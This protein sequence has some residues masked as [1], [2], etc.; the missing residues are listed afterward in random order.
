[1]ASEANR[2]GRIVVPNEIGHGDRTSWN[3]ELCH[4]KPAES[5]QPS[6]LPARPIPSA[7]RTGDT[8][9]LLSRV[10]T[11]FVHSIFHR[12]PGPTQ[13]QAKNAKLILTKNSQPLLISSRKRK[14]F[15]ISPLEWATPAGA[16]PLPVRHRLTRPSRGDYRSL[17]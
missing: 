9:S 6:S 3:C 12:T 15:P 10:R 11:R 17:A 13:R 8:S 4:R 5:K 2:S 7:L 1:M 14:I 16:L